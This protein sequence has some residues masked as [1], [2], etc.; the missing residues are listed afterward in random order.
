MK[1]DVEAQVRQGVKVVL[2]EML[3]RDE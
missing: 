1:R 3:Q 2:E